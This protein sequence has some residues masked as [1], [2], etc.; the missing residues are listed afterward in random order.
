MLLFISTRVCCFSF[1]SARAALRPVGS[2]V[3]PIGWREGIWKFWIW[4]VINKVRF[5][6]AYLA[7][8]KNAP[9]MLMC[10]LLLRTMH[11]FSYKLG[12]KEKLLG[13]LQWQLYDVH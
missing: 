11:F 9:N 4:P 6:F 13:V 10:L 2:W 7:L 3:A 12:P 8:Q 5:D 1:G